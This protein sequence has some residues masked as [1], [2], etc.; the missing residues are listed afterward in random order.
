MITGMDHLVMN[1]RNFDACR[2][3]YHGKLGLQE[4]AYGR[5]WD[6]NQVCVLSVGASALVINE[7]PKASPAL[8]PDSGQ[9]IPSNHD[10]TCWIMHFAFPVIDSW[11][12]YHE[13]ARRGLEW[14]VAPSDQPAGLH[15]I[16][17][18]LMEFEDPE[19]FTI[20]L[21]ERIDSAGRPMPVANTAVDL[22]HQPWPGCDRIDHIAFS[23]PDMEAKRHFYADI[24]GLAGTPPQPTTLGEQS[25]LQ[26]GETIVELIWRPAV[27]PPLHAG[28]V[29]LVAF[30][31]NDIGEAYET[32]RKRGANVS[33]PVQDG[34]LPEI[35]WQIMTLI[36]PDGL[37]V[38][39]VEPAPSLG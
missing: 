33:P 17:R 30:R 18:R 5:A 4:I 12:T 8:D 16:R 3:T 36:D 23:T 1:V 26:A 22:A 14:S 9:P 11:S 2:E 35:Q 28:T 24:L 15:H 25:D 10:N 34:P 13:L 29:T 19:L 7:D 39:L 38:Q 32:L 37:P 20:Q 21:A 27:S 6:G 31:V